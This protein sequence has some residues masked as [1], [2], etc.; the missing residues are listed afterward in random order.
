MKTAY[1]KNMARITVGPSQAEQ[2]L[3]VI[4]DILLSL[5]ERDPAQAESLSRTLL[6]KAWGIAGTRR[7]PRAMAGRLHVHCVS[8]R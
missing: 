3:F 5:L 6:A 1:N 2:R 7:L 4:W 8:N